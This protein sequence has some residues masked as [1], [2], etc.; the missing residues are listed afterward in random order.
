MLSF[1]IVC[2]VEIIIYDEAIYAIPFRNKNK[3]IG[4]DSFNLITQLGTIIKC[5]KVHKQG[6]ILEAQCNV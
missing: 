5:K 2:Y 6:K 1:R 4:R 3:L